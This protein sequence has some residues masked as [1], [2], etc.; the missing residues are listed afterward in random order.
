[1]WSDETSFE[2]YS[3][4]KGQWVEAGEK[5]TPRETV[6]W[7]ARIRVW[8]A[9]SS[10]GKTPLVRIPKKMTGAEFADLLSGTLIPLMADAFN[11]D[12]SAF[13]LAMDGDGVH[14]AKIVQDR[15]ETEGVSVLRPWPAH[16]PDLNPIENAWSI[17]EQHLQMQN[18][19]TERGLWLAMRRAWDAIDETTLLQLCGSVPRRLKAVRDAQGGHTRY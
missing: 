16:S 7:P 12:R 4:T 15:L 13:T 11:G 19:S 9:I 8:A 1:M 10:R 14:T 2:L 5:P 17:V 18:P 6:K 3:D